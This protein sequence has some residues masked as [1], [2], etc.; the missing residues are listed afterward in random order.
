M[1]SLLLTGLQMQKTNMVIEC[2]SR[3]CHWFNGDTLLRVRCVKL[4]KIIVTVVS[5]Y[6]GE[7]AM[8]NN[9]FIY[10]YVYGLDMLVV[11]SK[12]WFL[13]VTFFQATY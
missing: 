13:S 10:Y 5:G 9:K 8:I 2:I 6:K 4:N 1:E 7:W 12:L 3:A 11:F